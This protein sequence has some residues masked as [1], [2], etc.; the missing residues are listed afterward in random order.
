[1]LT[2]LDPGGPNCYRGEIKPT[3]NMTATYFLGIV[4]LFVLVI[5]WINYINLTTARAMQRAKEVGIRKT[6]GSFRGQLVG[7]FIFESTFL[8]LLALLLAIFLVNQFRLENL[9]ETK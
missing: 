9:P 4:G 3:G 6:L 2:P 5:A 1:M 7:Q 8:N